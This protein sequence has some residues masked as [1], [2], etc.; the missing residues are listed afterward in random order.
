MTSSVRKL[1][2]HF[3]LAVASKVFAQVMFAH[4]LATVANVVLLESQCWF[5]RNRN[6]IDMIF[7]ARLLQE[8]CRVTHGLV[9]H[10]R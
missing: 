2:R 8:K 5:H 9:H 1:L 10:L 3:F 6:T 7:V 4:F